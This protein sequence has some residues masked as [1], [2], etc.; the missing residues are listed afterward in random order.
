MAEFMVWFESKRGKQHIVCLTAPDYFAAI[1]IAKQKIIDAGF[2]K[3]RFISCTPC[4]ELDEIDELEE[5]EKWL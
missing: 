1:H 4:D 3:V 2:R 5:G